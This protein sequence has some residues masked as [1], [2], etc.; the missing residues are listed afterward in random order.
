[1][2]SSGQLLTHGLCIIGTTV[3][4]RI[5][6]RVCFNLP[7]IRKGLL[8]LRNVL[9]CEGVPVEGAKGLFTSVLG[10]LFCLILSA[11]KMPVLGAV[12][13]VVFPQPRTV[14]D[15][16]GSQSLFVKFIFIVENH[17]VVFLGNLKT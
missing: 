10:F 15:T 7:S 12:I 4:F 9:H 14:E 8:S 5:F 1:M 6:L 3:V 11:V 2:T 16:V 13:L 17:V